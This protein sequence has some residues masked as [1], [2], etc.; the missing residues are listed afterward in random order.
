MQ[1]LEINDQ[2]F[3]P[4]WVR[5]FSK[6]TALLNKLTHSDSSTVQNA[7]DERFVEEEKGW[8]NNVG[9]I[10]V[11]KKKSHNSCRMR[12]FQ[13]LESPSPSAFIEAKQIH[14]KHLNICNSQWRW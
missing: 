13:W 4:L 6:L 7:P 12:Q 8:D 11:V 2:G 3:E 10:L 14:T 1:I 5:L 9:K